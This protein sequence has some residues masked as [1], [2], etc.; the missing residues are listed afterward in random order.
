[1]QPKMDSRFYVVNSFAA[2]KINMKKNERT[3][4]MDDKTSIDDASQPAVSIV[5]N[6]EKTSCNET[7]VLIKHAG[8]N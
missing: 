3:K 1:M 7:N 8:R 2:L 5:P 4:I 6:S